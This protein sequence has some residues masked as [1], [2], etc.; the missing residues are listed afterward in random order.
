MSIGE[1][2]AARS[3]PHWASVAA[4]LKAAPG[5]QVSRRRTGPSAH[6]A[7]LGAAAPVDGGEDEDHRRRAEWFSV[8][9][10]AP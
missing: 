3:R 1:S 10:V 2:R 8:C 4:T 6:K 9:V 5:Q 7:G